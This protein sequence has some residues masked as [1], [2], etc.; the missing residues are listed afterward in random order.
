MWYFASSD[1]HIILMIFM[2]SHLSD[3]VTC[4]TSLYIPNKDLIPEV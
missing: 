1:T 2:L 4:S 3:L